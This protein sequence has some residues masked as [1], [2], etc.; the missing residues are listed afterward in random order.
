MGGEGGKQ[1]KNKW[2]SKQE[3]EQTNKIQTFVMAVHCC[4]QTDA[5]TMNI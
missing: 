1:Y 5:N 2:T 3:Q 4:G